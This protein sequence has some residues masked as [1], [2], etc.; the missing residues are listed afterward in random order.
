MN[1]LTERDDQGNWCLKGLPW[2]CLYW[3]E[4]ITT[5]VFDK[6]YGA[7]CKLQD[8]EDTGLSPKEV[9]QLKDVPGTTVYGEWI[10]VEERLPKEGKEV[11]V[12]YEYFRYGDYNCMFQK[13]G[14]GWQYGGHWSGDV[15]G[16]KA[17][18]IAWQPL[19]EPYRP[20]DEQPEDSQGI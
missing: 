14:I 5:T 13:H 2:K 3:G 17:R 19:P 10:P 15:S 18:C 1:R 11:L 16:T 8:Y 20:S 4:V 7:L 9:E 12:W 6:V